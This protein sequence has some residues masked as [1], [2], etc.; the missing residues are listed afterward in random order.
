MVMSRSKNIILIILIL[1]LVFGGIVSF[2]I[3]G[4]LNYGVIKRSNTFYYTP[5]SI[6]SPEKFMIITNGRTINIKHNISA[7]NYDIKADLFLK[8]EGMYMK[9]SDYEYFITDWDNFSSE[10]PSLFVHSIGKTLGGFYHPSWTARYDIT[11]NL[12]LRTDLLYDLYLDVYHSEINIDE[13]L[14]INELII[15]TYSGDIELNINETDINQI[16]INIPQSRVFTLELNQCNIS[17]IINITSTTADIRL[18]SFNSKCSNDIEWFVTSINGNI[19]TKIYQS[20]EIGANISASILSSSGNINIEYFDSLSTIGALFNASKYMASFQTSNLGGFE[21]D[22]VNIFK[23]TDFTSAK[24]IFMFDL[25]CSE[26]T[27]EGQSN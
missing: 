23:S 25:I 20:E 11:I 9:N 5:T 8:A 15:D 6:T 10:S 22:G 17:N 19:D 14:S 3:I 2:Y 21:M 16:S 13:D 7:V 12:T 18:N 4:I 1:G 26:I 27:V 24:Y